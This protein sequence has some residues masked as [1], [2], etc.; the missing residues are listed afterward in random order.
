MYINLRFFRNTEMDFLERGLTLLESINMT[1]DK[2]ILT[3]KHPLYMGTMVNLALKPPNLFCP[4]FLSP[5]VGLKFTFRFLVYQKL[6][7][8]SKKS[9]FVR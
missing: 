6:I 3:P 7:P 4:E 8:F 1:K 5:M 2:V 9:Y